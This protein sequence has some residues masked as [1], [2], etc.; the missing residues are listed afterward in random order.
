MVRVVGLEPTKPHQELAVLETAAF[1]VPP[2]PHCP[3][4]H[5]GEQLDTAPLTLFGGPRIVIYRGMARD[6]VQAVM[7]G[8]VEK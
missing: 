7:A 3:L 1:T 8:S 4:R 2:H 6:Y 5:E